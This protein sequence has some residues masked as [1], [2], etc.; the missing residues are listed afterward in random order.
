MIEQ[1]S[2]DVIAY[3]RM[4]AAARATRRPVSAAGLVFLTS[5]FASSMVVSAA[6]LFFVEPMFAKMVLPRLGGTPAVWNTCVVFFQAAMLAGYAY[7][8]LLTTRLRLWQQMVLHA[9]LLLVVALSLPVAIPEGWAPPVDRTPMFSL[10]GLLLGTV[11]APFLVVSAT[12]PLLQ[13]WFSHTSHP[14]ASDP[15]FLYAASNA[16]SIVALLGYPFV[17]EP[18]WALPLQ[19]RGW[20]AGYLVLAA[21]ILACAAGVSR[22]RVWD[23]R[24]AASATPAGLDAAGA[25]VPWRRR[26]RWMALAFVPS[27]LM[28]AVTTFLSTDIAAV[29]LLWIAPLTFYLLSFVVTFTARPVL[30]ERFGLNAMAIL[31][32]P[33]TLAMMLRLPGPMWLLMPLHL[34]T[35]FACALVLHRELAHD[36]PD[37]SHLT[38]FYVWL[39]VG[40]VLGGAF[41]TFVAPLAFTGVAEYPLLL[42]LACA[43]RPHTANR[44]GLRVGVADVALPLGFGAATL[45]LYFALKG[46][47][48]MLFAV[49]AGLAGMLYAACSK[50]PLRLA[51]GLAILFVGTEGVVHRQTD[52]LYAER[53][54]FG[55]LR[56]RTSEREG[57]SHALYHGSTLHGEQSR[58]PA[59]RRTPS[60]YYY[61]AGPIGQLFS[62][63]S[64][65]FTRVG[66]IGLGT[67]ALAAYATPNQQ[68]TFYEIDPAV[69]RVARTSRFFTYLEDCGAMCNVVLGDARLSLATAESG[70]YDAIVL[71][72][73]SSDAV[74]VH[75]LTRQAL[76]L[77]LAKLSD[78]GIL[79]FH[80]SNRHLTL[81]PVVGALAGDLGLAARVQLHRPSDTSRGRP[82]E[83]VVLARSEAQLGSLATDARWERLSGDAHGAWTDDYSNI[84]SVLRR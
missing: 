53:T 11:G 82:S 67:G 60:S 10:L 64:H 30:S 69:E 28:L 26:I 72:A 7:A 12:A 42:V 2:A 79:A 18:L 74:P 6:L 17:A 27:S 75:L 37:T 71:D 83:W 81:R 49:V 9:T 20:T 47:E 8:H 15:Y 32:L 38:E 78:D 31:L 40:G 59:L 56:V 45:A 77:Y 68:W 36:R 65:R 35:F 16:G 84:L 54:F 33:L 3:P 1:P 14:A 21:L 43:L 19:S 58:N 4:S 52:L 62:A 51:A 39:S 76:Q 63:L 48:R 34:A 25:A 22:W 80:I 55:V 70:G 23:G 57:G 44:V 66:V 5:L 50:H 13:R 29:P 46:G 61:D 73:F 24:S 41:N